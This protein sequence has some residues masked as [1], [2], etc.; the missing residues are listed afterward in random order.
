LKLLKE[1]KTMLVGKLGKLPAKF[2]SR[3]LRFSKYATGLPDPPQSCD[4]TPKIPSPL[5]MLGN[6]QYGDCGFAA[7]VHQEMTWVDNESQSLPVPSSQAVIA[8]YLAFTG[9][10]DTGVVLLDMLK[11]WRTTGIN[12]RK[13][14]AFA[15]VNNQ[16]PKEVQ[17]AIWLF[18][19]IFIGINLPV[20]W[21]QDQVWDCPGTPTGSY[22]PGSWGGHAICSP[23]YFI[24]AG[25]SEAGVYVI[26][27]GQIILL[28]WKAF[29]IYVDETYAILSTDWTD[30]TRPAPN[31]FDLATLNADLQAVGQMETPPVPLPNP[32]PG[33]GP[34]PTPVPVPAPTGPT[35]PQVKTLGEQYTHALAAAV[36]KQFSHRMIIAG[37]EAAA[38][39]SSI[40][41]GGK[42]AWDAAATKLFGG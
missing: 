30:G 41:E 40:I 13:I 21:Q 19:G 35:L 7:A 42:T 39:A 33:P 11:F 2:D 24:V 17:Q 6:D 31:G 18:G 1:I 20:A 23:K 29:S 37:H 36:V 22:A 9:G 16:N 27:W 34:G 38:E 3:T 26:S 12:G 15:L 4:Y 32:T 28:T 5:G 14:G 10:Q 25:A 8:E